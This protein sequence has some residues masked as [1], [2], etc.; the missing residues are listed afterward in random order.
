MDCKYSRDPTDQPKAVELFGVTYENLVTETTESQA[1]HTFKVVSSAF[2]Q[3]GS[4]PCSSA[5]FSARLA[6]AT[7]SETCLLWVSSSKS[8]LSTVNAST[9][10]GL[11]PGSS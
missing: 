1:A 8:V 4:E 9:P 3:S 7:I 2:N 6:D 11:R 10:P 5:V